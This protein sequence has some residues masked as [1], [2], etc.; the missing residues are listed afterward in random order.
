MPVTIIII[1]D[2]RLTFDKHVSDLCKMTSL[3]IYARQE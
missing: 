1:I 2:N 3:E